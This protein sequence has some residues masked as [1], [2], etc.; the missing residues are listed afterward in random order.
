M[1]TIKIFLA[2]SEE[3]KPER[4]ELADLVEN[5]NNVLEKQD[6]TVRLVKWEYLDSSMGP[7]HKQ[8]D[9]NDK[10]RECDI[11]LVLYWTK[12]GMYTKTEL[13]TAY[14]ELCAGRNPHKIYIYFKDGSEITE[15]LKKFRDEFPAKYGHFYCTFANTDTLKADFLLQFMEYQGKQLK[16]SNAIEI[17]DSQI[18]VGGK[19]YVDLKNVPFAGNNEE[20]NILLKSIKKTKKL[21]AVT[22]PDDEEYAEYAQ[23]LIELQERQKNMENSLWDTALMITRLSTTQC[24][25]RLE[26]AMKLFTAGDNKGA[27]AVLNEEEIEHDVQHNLNLIRLGEEGKKGLKINIDE[28]CLRIKTLKNEMEDGW[29]LESCKLH[30]RIIKLTISLYGENSL[31][32]ASAMMDAAEVIYL[33]EDFAKL[34]EYTQKALNIRLEI[35]GEQHLD[36]AQCYNDLGVVSGKLGDFCKYHEYVCKGLDIRLALNA[37]EAL[38][39]ESY[40]TACFSYSHIGDSKKNLEYQQKSLELRRKAYGEMHLETAN[41][42]SNIGQ[43]YAELQDAPNYLKYSLRSLEIKQA[44]VGDKHPDTGLSYNNVADAY[45]LLEKYQEAITLLEKA[46]K[47]SL[48]TIGKFKPGTLVHYDNLSLAYKLNGNIE[49]ALDNIMEA[50]TISKKINGETHSKTL[51]LVERAGRLLSDYGDGKLA[52]NYLYHAFDVRF[53]IAE[54]QHLPNGPLPSFELADLCHEIGTIHFGMRDYENAERMLNN[55]INI[56][57]DFEENAPELVE[58]F[59]HLGII[60]DKQ[61]KQEEAKKCIEYSEK[62]KLSLTSTPQNNE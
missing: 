23:E 36:T 61:S 1:K 58:W 6:I 40:N 46:L 35:L 4:L 29:L 19:T 16:N 55:A 34:F 48:S 42:Y 32:T 44:I 49:K 25:E 12:F 31:E 10:L 27:L 33:L 60:Y 53:K 50:I 26:R 3:L 59:R 24:S 57:S 52:L 30:E 21:L 14:G 62:I 22:E 9:Y 56:L 37:S 51:E 18:V 15:E 54:A 7:Q 38:L 39:A 41:S 8:E 45:M 47:V 11:C 28:Y 2:S 5:I 43:A 17:K 13:D 20:Y